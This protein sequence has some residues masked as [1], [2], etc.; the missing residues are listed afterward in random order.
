[1]RTAQRTLA[2]LAGL[3]MVVFL[4]GKA[5]AQDVVVPA[6]AESAIESA[7][8]QSQEAEK[9]KSQEAEKPTQT[10][11]PKG[12][13]PAVSPEELE[14][15]VQ[16]LDADSFADRQAASQRLAELGRAAIDALI[17][18]ATSES[19]EANVRA[20][21]ILKKHLD[22]QDAELKKATK[23]ALEKIAEGP[24]A[25]SA[26]RAKDILKA[27]EER[28]NVEK[29]QQQ[30]VQVLGG[31]IQVAAQAQM[32]GGQGV[33][34]V[35]I[36][37]NVKTIEGEEKDLKFRIVE[38]PKEGIT[39]ELTRKKEGKEV[40][41]KFQ[42]KNLEELQ[43]K[44]PEAYE[45][46]KRHSQA[47]GVMIQPIQVQPIQV[48]PIQVPPA[49][50]IRRNNLETASRLL[51]IWISQVERLVTEDAIKDSPKES[52]Q[53]L[54]KKIVEA[55]QALEK[56]EKRIQETLEQKTKGEKPKEEQKEEKKE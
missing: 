26:R 44:H 12:S 45:V 10:E 52:L 23:E 8:Q 51:P 47:G 48:Q 31:R 19:L 4:A 9:P 36:V 53:E 41:E 43:K 7:P 54:H 28:Q 29:L 27:Y 2:F 35:Q 33:Q 38:D 1:M 3:S 42:A 56:L 14:K 15:L 20:L 17:R 22:S 34:R 40:T 6:P 13:P 11:S 18:A 25:S 24:R 16:Q 21:D 39:V 32:I 5:D 46:Y 49:Q 50:V 55:R 37:N 30:G